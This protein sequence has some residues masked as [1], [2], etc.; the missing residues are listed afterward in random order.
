MAALFFS[1]CGG[2]LDKVESKKVG[3]NTVVIHELGDPDYLNPVTSGSAG[4]TYV[5]TNIFQSLI[6]ID[7]KSLEFIGQLA[8][9]R[10]AIK[11]IDSGEYAG[12]MSLSYEI[13][14]EA[15]WDNG[16]AITGHD[17]VFTIKAIKNPKV[18]AD[19]VRPY[20]DFIDDI[21]VDASNPK[22]ITILSKERY[23][24]AESSSGTQ[25]IIPAYIYDPQGLM[26]DFSIKQLDDPA[27]KKALLNNPKIK[28]FAEAF[29]SPKFARE[30]GFVVGSGPYDFDGWETGQYISLSRKKDWWGDKANLV[31]RPDKVIYKI[32]TDW[33][34]AVTSLKGEDLDIA[35]RIRPGDFQDLLDNDR[36]K[37]HYNLSM[38]T[39]LSYTYLGFNRKK[40]ALSDQRVRRAIAHLVD[41]QEI[42]DVLLYGQGDLLNSPIHPT[43]AY[44]NK[45]LQDIGFNVD[46]A[47][48]LLKEAGWDDTDGDGIADKVINGEKQ[49]LSLEFKYNNGN[50]VRK[51]IG[52]LL[53]E[54]AIRAGVKIEVVGREWT[55]VLDENKRREFDIKCIGWVQSPTPDDLKQ[56]WH[57]DYDSPDGDNQVGFGNADSDRLIDKIRVTLDESERNELYKQ[58]QKL[59][60][61]DQPYVFLYSPKGRL[62]IHNRF[63][64]AEASIRRPGYNE[65]AFKLKGPKSTAQQ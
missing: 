65:R 17:F 58:L 34:A 21:V 63:D 24:L 42:I 61:D 64:D 53:K 40:P 31:A 2:E 15:K 25:S 13:H 49:Q 46:K 9:S 60:Y 19:S 14:P 3:D 48:A 22:K 43:K 47:K 10:P 54:N 7:F 4:A 38:P 11:T 62:A 45:N 44:Y 27:Q 41:R 32:V 23:L 6:E 8:T 30:K 28:Q 39:E 57:T 36:F 37:Q 35:R 12:G 18:N 1:A 26:K 50:D 16:Q 51:N 59:I 52:L 56:I 5:Q 29:N 55:V 20:L 33:T